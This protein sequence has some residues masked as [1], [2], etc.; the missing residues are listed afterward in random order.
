MQNENWINF[1]DNDVITTRSSDEP[2]GETRM[3][4]V[5]IIASGKDGPVIQGTPEKLREI[6]AKMQEALAK[7]PVPEQA[8]R[9]IRPPA[10]APMMLTTRD[11]SGKITQMTAIL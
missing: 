8:M 11:A 6:V 2:I 4:Y 3:V 9:V 1:D 5:R 10:V 7:Y